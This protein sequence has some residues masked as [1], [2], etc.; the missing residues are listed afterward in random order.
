MKKSLGL[1]AAMALAA[2]TLSACGGGTEEYCNSLEDAEAEFS[3]I[4]EGDL[5][6]FGDAIDRM[7]EIGADAPDEVADD[8]EVLTGALD[9]MEQALDDAGLTFDDLGTLSTTGELPEGVD[10][11]ALTGLQEQ[12]GSLDSDETNAA[13]D[14]I[15]AH[16]EEEC[17]ITLGS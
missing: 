12:L 1:T 6:N 17:G 13:G 7:R 8:W 16:A 11:S 4:D 5:G 3:A 2:A 10:P 14:A 9:D 15:D